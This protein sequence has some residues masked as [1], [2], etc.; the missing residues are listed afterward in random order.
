MFLKEQLIGGPTSMGCTVA[1]D[2]CWFC[3]PE[4]KCS[5]PTKSDGTPRPGCSSK[6][7][8]GLRCQA[9]TRSWLHLRRTSLS[10]NNHWGRLSAADANVSRPLTGGVGTFTGNKVEQKKNPRCWPRYNPIT[11]AFADVPPNSEDGE[12][13]LIKDCKPCLLTCKTSKRSAR[14]VP[15]LSA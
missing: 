2:G 3:G 4:K 14:G 8:G 1:K 7:E 13:K 10:G 15:T 12:D 5:C 11:D 6:P 9:T